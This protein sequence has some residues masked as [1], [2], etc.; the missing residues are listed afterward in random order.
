MSTARK[1]SVLTTVRSSGVLT[2][3]PRARE[4]EQRRL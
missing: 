2:M 4:P 1:R 3:T